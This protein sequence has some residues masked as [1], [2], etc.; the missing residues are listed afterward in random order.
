[1]SLGGHKDLQESDLLV[2]P[3]VSIESVSIK[4]TFWKGVRKFVTWETS[5][6]MP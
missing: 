5:T 2:S 6:G 1:M 4:M 3:L